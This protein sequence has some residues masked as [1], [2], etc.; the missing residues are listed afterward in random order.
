M[1]QIS[2]AAELAIGVGGSYTQVGWDATS[3][4][5][6]YAGA[7][8]LGDLRLG[9]PFKRS[10]ASIEFFG[11]YS[12]QFLENTNHSLGETNRQTGIGGGMDF[13]Y[14]PVFLGGQYE[15]VTTKISGT[16]LSADLSYDAYGPRAGFR[17]RLK[18]RFSIMA[19]ALA[20]F[21]SLGVPVNGINQNR[22]VTEYR[23]FVLFRFNLFGAGKRSS[24]NASNS[25]Y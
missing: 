20:E 23:A 19:G 18:G 8:A 24:S 25:R 17:I 6:S 11:S 1:S 14:G 7:G 13:F 9:I 10:R 2:A 5:S 12:D 22:D 3:G 15:S 21:G 4:S 16:N